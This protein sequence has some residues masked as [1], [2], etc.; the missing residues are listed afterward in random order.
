MP[1]ARTSKRWEHPTHRYAYVR[2]YRGM[3]CT[4]IRG[5]PPLST[6]Y[7]W[8]PS[9]RVPAMRILDQR[10][11][12]FEG[13]IAEGPIGEAMTCG[14]LF[15]QFAAVRFPRITKG[16]QYQFMRAAARFLH[17]GH[18]LDQTIKIRAYIVKRVAEFDGATSTLHGYLKRLRTL[19]AFA[20][21]EGWM[22]ANPVHR[23]MLPRVEAPDPHPYTDAEIDAITNALTGRAQL[24]VRL[25][26]LTGCRAGEI[27]KLTWADVREDHIVID[28]KRTR[29][30]VPNK[31]IIP[32]ELAPGLRELLSEVRAL[33]HAPEVLGLK[34]Y[35]HMQTYVRQACARLGI[36]YR[37]LHAIRAWRVNQWAKVDRWPEEVLTAIAGHDTTISKKHYRTPLTAAE[38]VRFTLDSG[39]NTG[40][41][42]RTQT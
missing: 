28:G 31:R 8:K 25:L 16:Q 38:L 42:S 27:T 21:D 17:D 15:E 20:V 9:S 35:Y 11:A 1:R 14:E 7:I 32:Y 24:Y 41:P 6:G 29:K 12:V 34:F 26:A 4:V 13:R 19:F 10:L 37:G 18:R 40:G 22:K 30:D 33:G 2:E 36:E 3:A 5:G 23:D 39:P